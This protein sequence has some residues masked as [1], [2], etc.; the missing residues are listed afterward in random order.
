MAPTELLQSRNTR[1]PTA[2]TL[3]LKL[4]NYG[5]SRWQ[6]SV[7]AICLTGCQRTSLLP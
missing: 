3:P 1:P 6:L 4:R 5:R 2:Q 7:K